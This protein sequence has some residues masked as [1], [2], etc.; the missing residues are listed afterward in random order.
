[1]IEPRE[2]VNSTARVMGFVIRSD[3][4]QICALNP[5]MI[6]VVAKPFVTGRTT[7]LAPAAIAAPMEPTLRDLSCLFS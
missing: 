3:K 1:M 6:A 5:S 4:C 7:H 2:T